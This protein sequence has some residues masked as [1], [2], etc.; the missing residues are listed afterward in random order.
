[1]KF[2]AVTFCNVNQWRRSASQERT[3]NMIATIYGFND[4]LRDNFNWTDFYQ[5][6][7]K[8]WIENVTRNSLDEQIGANGLKEMLVE[9][10]WNGVQ[11]CDVSDFEKV[12]TDLGVCYTFNNPSNPAEV[13]VVNRPG[14]D[15]GLALT[16]NILYDEYIRG[17]FQGAGI[18]VCKIT[19]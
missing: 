4:T 5:F 10:F 19:S 16:L 13:R 2:P 3:L 1:M 14:T 11:K 18:K 6:V 15:S 17:E 12:M 8:K 7:D 9:C